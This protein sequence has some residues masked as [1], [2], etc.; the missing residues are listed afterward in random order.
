MIPSRQKCLLIGPVIC[1]CDAE[2]YA[3]PRSKVR[4]YGLVASIGQGKKKYSGMAVKMAEE[5]KKKKEVR[6]I[7][8]N[9]RFT[10]Q[11][12][13]GRKFAITSE[14]KNRRNY[15]TIPQKRRTTFR[16]SASWSLHKI[17]PQKC[18]QTYHL[19]I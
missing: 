13:R 8:C 6:I 2:L 11:K 3:I 18:N 17:I 9:S 16:P 12:R 19:N 5:L 1:L 7:N 15:R 4:F 10:P 14:L